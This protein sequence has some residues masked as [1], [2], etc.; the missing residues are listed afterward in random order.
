MFDH[1]DYK[2]RLL[3]TIPGGAHT[4]SRGFDQYPENAPQ[5]FERGSGAYAYT[6]EG[7]KFLDFGMALRSVNIGYGQKEIVKTA[8]QYMSFGNNLTRPSTIELEAAER[9]IAMV[10]SV[11]MIKFTKNGSTA[12]TAAVKLARGYTGKNRV[13]VCADHP[14]FSYDDWFIGST[15]LQKGIP[16]DTVSHTLKF[17]YNDIESVKVAIERGEGSIACLVM[18]PATVVHPDPSQTVEG[19]NFLHDVQRLCRQHGIVF[20]LDEMITGFRW[21]ASGAQSY[22][23]VEPDLCTFGKAM[24][25][26]F[27]VAAVAGRRELMALGSIEEQG[28]ERLFLLSSTH[29]AEMNSLGAFVATMDYLDTHQVIDANWK[30]GQRFIDLFNRLSLSTGVSEYF[31]AKGIA[32]SPVLEIVDRQGAPCPLLRTLLMQELIG[33]NVL[34]PWVSIAHAHGDDE[35]S[36]L[37]SALLVAFERCA[38]ALKRGDV[39]S[40][41]E[42]EAVK[43]VFRKYN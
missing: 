9:L 19:E 10:P 11:D 30:T 26:G 23:G 7:E 12:V 1:S 14:F 16:E 40:S 27:S 36:Q 33:E 15:Q 32:C 34:M 18:E 21:D 5:I 42:G 6:P 2:R 8:Y 31:S 28:A 25:N 41:I 4:Y 29:G 24:A 17:Q 22:Y 35:F 43:P 3:K 39:Q 20:I 37:E 13:L 38:S